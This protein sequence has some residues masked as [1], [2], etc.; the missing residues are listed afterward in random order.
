[1]NQLPL[2][3]LAG[4]NPVYLERVISLAL[5][6]APDDLF[7]TPTI[8]VRSGARARVEQNVLNVLG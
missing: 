4:E 1:L 7:K 2:D 3:E 6:V 8:K 5:G